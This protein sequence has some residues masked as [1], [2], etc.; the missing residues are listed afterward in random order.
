MSD[1]D[2]LVVG[3]T[4]VDFIPD[5]PGE[6]KDVESFTRRPG[7]APANVAVRLSALGQIPWFWTRIG[8]DA[9]GE[10]LYETLTEVG[11]PDRFVTRDGEAATTLAFVGHDE[12]ADRSFSF[13]RDRTADT[14][15]QSGLVP[16]ETL[17][18]ITCVYVGGVL[19]ASEPSRSAVLD[20]LER[21]SALGCTVYFDPNFRPELWDAGEFESTVGDAIGYVDVIK[22]T[23]RELERCGFSGNT[24]KQ[25]CEAVCRR[26]PHSVLM[27]LGPDGAFA[28]C[29]DRSFW[30]A[31]QV[32]HAGF[33]VD[34]VDTTGA[35]DAF[36]AGTLF[37]IE[38]GLT[39]EET[40]EVANTMAALSTTTEGAMADPPSRKRVDEFLK[41]VS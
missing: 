7:G 28:Y 23:V 38:E 24:R 26:G 6:L 27:T 13:Y 36:V 4:L 19:L 37:G 16:D 40:L 41:T 8:D 11:I 31:A 32:E 5:R 2:V 33:D 17:R 20:L 15:F 25:V 34:V 39:I 1:P 29:D 9:F 30:E 22:A 12:N 3:E 18:D 10:F 14:R 35:G 21:A